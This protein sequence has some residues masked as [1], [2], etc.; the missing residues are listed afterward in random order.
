MTLV[1]SATQALLA[2]EAGARFISCFMG[3][4]D[5]CSI[6]SSE[7]LAGIVAALRPAG[8]GS[9]VLA[10][11]IRDPQHVVMAARLGCEVATVPGKVLRQMLEHPLTAAGIERFNA[12]W[13]SR[14]ELGEWLEGLVSAGATAVAAPASVR[15]A[16]L[17]R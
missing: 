7:V 14:P 16:A 2:A 6:D 10:A 4:L 17:A 8:L 3:R 15:V 9:E 11:S 5:D 12:D 13:R 1:F